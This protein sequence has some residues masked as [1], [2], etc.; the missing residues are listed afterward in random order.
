MAKLKSQG[1]CAAIL[2]IFIKIIMTASCVKLRT[3][4]TQIN[5]I[6][7]DISSYICL[8]SLLLQLQ[9]A[10]VLDMQ[11]YQLPYGMASD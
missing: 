4:I 6:H 5:F 2:M 11:R 9:Y 8:V 7:K 3:R 1:T 10:K